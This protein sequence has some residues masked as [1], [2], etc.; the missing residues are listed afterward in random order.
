[1]SAS[2]KKKLRKELESAQLTEKQL[3]EQKAAKK[4]KANSVAFI[5]V[6]AVVLVLAIG[7]FAINSF[8][9]SGIKERATDAL[10]IGSHTLSNAE[11]NY[12]FIDTINREYT[13]LYSQ[14]GSYAS[15][16][17]GFD[18]SIAL[19]EQEY[20]DARTYA[21][22]YLEQAIDDIKE[23][24]TIYD[25]AVA[26]NHTC[27]EEELAEI[28]G[29]IEA[30]KSN[31]RANGVSFSRYLKAL[32][33]VGATKR[34]FKNYLNVVTTASSYQAKYYDSLTYDDAAINAHSSANPNKYSSFDFVS[35]L[36]DYEDFLTGGTQNDS[37]TTVYSDEERAAALK[38]AEEVA[39]E[40]VASNADSKAKLDEA[41]K[42]HD[43]YKDVSTATSS[44]SDD[45]LYTSINNNIA[46]WLANKDRKTGDIGYVEYEVTS[47]TADG[48]TEAVEGYYVVVMLGR[49]ENEMNLVNVR[50]ILIEPTQNSTNED[51]TTYSS[52]EEWDIAEMKANALLDEWKAGDM[53]EESF[54]KLATANT[55]DTGSVENGGLYEDVTPGSMVENFDAWIF[56]ASR[57]AG[58]TGVVETEYGFHVMYFVGTTEETYREHMITSELREEDFSKWLEEITENVS[59]NVL[60]TT[61]VDL[62]LV[63][64]NLMY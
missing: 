24:Y 3:A 36:V 49:G 7:I 6:L 47:T 29:A 18:P 41:I 19:N 55:A 5:A 60:D 56:D 59:V 62:D 38:A 61:L 26:Q 51:G 23:I 8:K 58:D 16:L 22:H 57:K 64:E 12:F 15:W 13:N 33:G 44:E 63:Y 30:I 31:A 39:K 11:L 17:L 25:I 52:T 20:D 40:L 48:E 21:D 2:S 27:T 1:M 54:A 10:T 50:H 34:D 28:D 14:Y 45:S 35:F 4:A 46:E 43:K 42:A 32:Y 9:S 37:G 53:S